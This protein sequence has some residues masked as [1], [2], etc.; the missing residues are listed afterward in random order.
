MA[1]KPLAPDAFLKNA[2][3]LI[4]KLPKGEVAYATSDGQVFAK[5][6]TKEQRKLHAQNHAFNFKPCLVIA[7]YIGEK[8]AKK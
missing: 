5:A 4:K 7:E 3:K 8:E 6:A 2:E 1:K